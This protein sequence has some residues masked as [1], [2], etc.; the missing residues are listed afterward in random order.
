MRLR[1]VKLRGLI[2]LHRGL[3]VDE[4]ELNLR[5]LSGVI[6]LIGQNGAGKTTLLE[7]LS[8]FRTFPSRN[9]GLKDGIQLRDS[10]KDLSFEF[11]GKECR[12]LVTADSHSGKSDGF[13]WLDGEPLTTGKISELDEQLEKLLGPKDTFFQSVFAAQS[14][15]TLLSLKPAKRKEFFVE[16]LGLG[17]LQEYSARAK[18]VAGFVAGKISGLQGVVPRIEAAI[19]AGCVQEELSAERDRAIWITKWQER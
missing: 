15:E 5:G 7:S 3:G 17:K 19:A 18:E 12:C 13:L 8:P 14:A 6:A 2:G 1:S 16:F 10:Y 4:V 9:I 11:N